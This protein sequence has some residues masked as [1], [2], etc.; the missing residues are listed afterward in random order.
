[1][2]V[3]ILGLEK[4]EIANLVTELNELLANF[5]VYYQSLRGLNWNIRGKNFFELHLKFEEF[6]TDAQKK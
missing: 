4:V 1:M 3:T 6:Y 5:K 2:S